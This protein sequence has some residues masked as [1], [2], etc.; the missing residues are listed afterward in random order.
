METILIQ[1][2]AIVNKGERT[3]MSTR[4]DEFIPLSFL[5]DEVGVDATRYFLR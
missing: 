5:I 2:V 1:F 4:E 3:K